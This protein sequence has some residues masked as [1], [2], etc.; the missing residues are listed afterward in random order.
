MNKIVSL[1][2]VAAVVLLASAASANAAVYSYKNWTGTIGVD[3][4]EGYSFSDTKNLVR[5]VTDRSGSEVMED[6]DNNPDTPATGTGIFYSES[7]IQGS[8]TYNA[9][10]NAVDST[11]ALGNQYNGAVSNF[12][13]ETFK[14]DSDLEDDTN[15]KQ[16]SATG[17]GAIVGNQ[18]LDGQDL[19]SLGGNAAESAG[20]S[21]FNTS[22]L[23]AEFTLTGMSINYVG[24]SFI[25]ASQAL[26]NALDPFGFASAGNT[27]LV[28]QLIFKNKLDAGDTKQYQVASFVTVTCESGCVAPAPAP[29]VP[30]PAA[31]WLMGSGLVGLAGIARRRR[32]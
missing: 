28:I 25:G 12:F 30:V 8:F 16:A 24:D 13:F 14:Y 7:F 11:N 1:K 29:E 31:A 17:G 20:W 3:A 5:G 21:G 15:F 26:P 9:A 4:K 27:N 10:D 18:T 23:G 6:A 32:V 19:V 22:K 2:A